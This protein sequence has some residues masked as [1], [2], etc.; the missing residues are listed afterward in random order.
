MI[1][2]NIVGK[3][4]KNSK[5]YSKLNVDIWSGMSFDLTLSHI[6]RALMPHQ[7]TLFENIVKTKEESL[8]LNIVSFAYNVFESVFKI[9]FVA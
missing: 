4:E 5:K 9:L 6:L 3:G 8:I 7:K 2:G 1:F